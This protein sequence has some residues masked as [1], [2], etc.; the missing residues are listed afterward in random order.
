MS[1]SLAYARI[2][3]RVSRSGQWL[4]RVTT[5]A[6]DVR[7]TLDVLDHVTNLRAF[8]L[9]I[10]RTFG[11]WRKKRFR[12]SLRNNRHTQFREARF[13]ALR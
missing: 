6:L 4:T 7:A 3:P 2:Q 11:L 10:T 5:T 1:A 8:A 13:L 12:Q 9:Y